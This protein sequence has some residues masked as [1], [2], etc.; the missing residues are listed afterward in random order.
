MDSSS[1]IVIIQTAFPGDVILTLP[2]VQGL[3]HRFPNCRMSMVVIPKAAEL[4]LNHPDLTEIVVYDK[5]GSD[6]GIQG[7]WRL[8]KT[9]RLRQFNIAL[10]PH[11]SFRSAALAAVAGIP[12]RVGFDTSAGRLLLTDVVRY[13]QSL[14]EVDRN[15]RLATLLLKEHLERE[16]PRLFPSE[17]DR[18]T[19]DELLSS[20][21]FDQ[22]KPMIG[23]APGSV[24]NTKRWPEERFRELIRISS[25]KGYRV[26]LVGGKE[27]VILCE[28]LRE[29][30]TQTSVLSLAGKLTFLQSGELIRRCA[31][32]IANDSAPMHLALAMRTPVVAI[33]GATIPEFGFAPYGR[34][35][36]IVEV[37]DLS[38]R[39][40]SIHGGAQC[41]IGTFD[42][43]VTISA[44]RVFKTVEEVFRN[45]EIANS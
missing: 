22:T 8:A 21:T 27:D 1:N 14:H 29:A 15:A 10:I 3:K 20:R 31:V 11:R 38:C 19:V 40:C 9:I 28:R 34:Y 44:E 13:E 41:P 17:N 37:K 36:R 30:T 7:F 32:L 18:L 5:R 23:I 33:F 26:V 4:L 6:A 39:P 24:W 42:C 25:G 45:R 2:L 35:D 12:R 43:M 16:F